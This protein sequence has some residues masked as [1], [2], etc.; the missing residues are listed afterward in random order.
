LLTKI[1][2]IAFTIISLN[3]DVVGQ[4]DCRLQETVRTSGPRESLFGI[5]LRPKAIR[6]L[7]EVE[8][9]AR[10][11]IQEFICT[12]NG[13][14]T[15][16]ESNIDENGPYIRVSATR[17]INENTIVHE[18]FHLRLILKKFPQLT[19]W[20]SQAD[21]EIGIADYV[22]LVCRYL[23]P[24]IHHWMFYPEMRRMG[25]IP[26]D[27]YSKTPERLAQFGFP[28]EVKAAL[29][30][31]ER[32]LFLFELFLE[33]P[34]REIIDAIARQYDLNGWNEEA[35]T[36]QKMATIIKNADLSTPIKMTI[37]IR[38]CLAELK[39]KD[40]DLKIGDI[41]LTKTGQIDRSLAPVGVVT[42]P[43]TPPR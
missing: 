2:L 28:Y 41:T 30:R 23:N 33:I 34:E 11:P 12:D 6:L 7:I 42:K 27:G 37:A 3:R 1:A 18:L 8:T 22:Y 15:V 14:A 19:P 25:L 39:N 26:Q 10:A 43:Y 9:L 4:I 29:Y 16:G 35:R 21:V 31:E 36:A 32:I 13:G 24:V 38:K 20:V 17:G 40:L 5:K